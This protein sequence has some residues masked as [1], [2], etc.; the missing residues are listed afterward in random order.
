MFHFPA[1]INKDAGEPVSIKSRQ[2]NNYNYNILQYCF[3]DENFTLVTDEGQS[4]AFAYMPPRYTT[5]I[6]ELCDFSFVEDASEIISCSEAIEGTMIAFFWNKDIGKWEICTRNGVGG[7]YSFKRPTFKDEPPLKTFR[8]M[9]LDVF[10]VRHP[11][12]IIT[13]LSDIEELSDLSTDYCYICILQHPDNHIVYSQSLPFLHL[14]AVY[15][16][17][18]IP[19]LIEDGDDMPLITASIEEAPV[20]KTRAFCCAAENIIDRTA[21]EIGIFIKKIDDNYAANLRMI[22]NLHIYAGDID[23]SPESLY[24]PPAWIVTNKQTG[25]RCEIANPHYELAKSL[26]NIQPNMRYQYLHLR[27]L[28]IVGEYLNAFPQ[29]KDSFRRLEGEYNDFVTEVYNAYVKFYIV[30]DRE[31]AIPKKYFVHAA[32]IHH[33]I[34]LNLENGRSKIT[35]DTVMRYFSVVP[36]TKMF[37]NLTRDDDA[38]T[39]TDPVAELD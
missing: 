30:K 3:G 33:G 25:H 35:R 32:R 37:Y 5:D 29:Y 4:T 23:E 21:H 9:V 16:M 13:D 2:S 34:Y 6:T 14:V 31:T 38:P 36:P 15:D 11:S 17:F 10:R 19:P 12:S 8:E 20:V 22:G 26:R 1:P 7:K 24:Y 27:L 28:G 18:S 39:K